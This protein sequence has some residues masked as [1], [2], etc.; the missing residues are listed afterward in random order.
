MRQDRRSVVVLLATCL[1]ACS[2]YHTIADPAHELQPSPKSSRSVR[3][4]QR[5][6]KRLALQSASVQGDS[7][8]GLTLNGQAMAIALTDVATVE[9]P[10]T[11]VGAT[12]VVVT[13]ATILLTAG[14]FAVVA[15]EFSF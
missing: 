4:T 12:V 10:R 8:R 13:G 9:A 5:D 7:L 3:V 2:S 6:G 1:V 11:K 15:P 14:I